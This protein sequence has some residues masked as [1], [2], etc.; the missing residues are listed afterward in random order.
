MAEDIKNRI[1]QLVS[2][3]DFSKREAESLKHQLEKSRAQVQE[4]TVKLVASSPTPSH[5]MNATP[6]RELASL[7]LREVE[8]EEHRSKAMLHQLRRQ[9]EEKSERLDAT[10]KELFAAN[11]RFL[12]GQ[13]KHKNAHTIEFC[14]WS[15]AFER[16][17]VEA[18]KEREVACARLESEANVLEE[19]VG[20]LLEELAE[21]KGRD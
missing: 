1:E 18:E 3:G 10:R 14:R 5:L 17:F 8:G 15:E 21:S 20:S 9:F 7:I 12:S 4:L 6:N 19:L 11:E 16:S 2:E 13:K